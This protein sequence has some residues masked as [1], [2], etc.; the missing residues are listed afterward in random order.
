MKKTNFKCMYLVDDFLYNKVIKDNPN[1]STVPNTFKDNPNNSTLQN[2]FKK[3]FETSAHY[4]PT[5]NNF[6]NTT[7]TVPTLSLGL[8]R[9]T[10]PTILPSLPT[11]PTPYTSTL[12]PLLSSTDCDCLDPNKSSS[13][14]NKKNF[15]SS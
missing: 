6:S 5:L 3:I 12:E 8:N 2:T 4:K 14:I 15:L 7:D 9:E 10:E 13:T 1:N 11:S